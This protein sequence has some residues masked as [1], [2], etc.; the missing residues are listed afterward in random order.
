[1]VKEKKE[2][3]HMN[4]SGRCNPNMGWDT[5]TFNTHGCI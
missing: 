2:D 5:L 3:P 4:I 1:M